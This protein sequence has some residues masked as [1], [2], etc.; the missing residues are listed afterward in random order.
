MGMENT[1]HRN[2]MYISV[3]EVTTVSLPLSTIL[4]HDE[5]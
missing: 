5:F 4:A 3:F 1:H 2:G